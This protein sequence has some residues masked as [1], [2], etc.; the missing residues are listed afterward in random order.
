MAKILFVGKQAKAT[1]ID[2]IEKSKSKGYYAYPQEDKTP[3]LGIRSAQ[4]D[5]NAPVTNIYLRTYFGSDFEEVLKTVDAD[6]YVLCAADSDELKTDFD[7]NFIEEMTKKN[8]KHYVIDVDITRYK[9]LV[10]FRKKTDKD[11]NLPALF[12][13]EFIETL[14]KEIFSIEKKDDEFTVDETPLDKLYLTLKQELKDS[15]KKDVLIAE[16]NKLESVLLCDFIDPEHKIKAIAMFEANCNALLNDASSRKIK[17]AV[18]A[19]LAGVTVGL[20]VGALV[21][22]GSIGIGCAV[23]AVVPALV[24]GII[25]TVIAATA[26]AGAAGVGGYAA[27]YSVLFKPNVR[28]EHKVVDEVVRVAEEQCSPA[29]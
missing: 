8:K 11:E 29:L 3:G 27:G 20:L 24:I 25:A 28:K 19:L 7:K 9:D 13:D 16:Y 12:G 2:L 18:L 15:P 10:T 17:A 4:K 6:I 5:K 26:T 1:T 14:E 21:F 22:G 23:G